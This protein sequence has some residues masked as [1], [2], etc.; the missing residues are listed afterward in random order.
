VADQWVELDLLG[1]ELLVAQHLAADE[2]RHAVG[3]LD[4]CVGLAEHAVQRVEGQ[5]LDAAV[6]SALEPRV[7]AREEAIVVERD[8]GAD[9]PTTRYSPTSG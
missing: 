7:L 6:G 1:V 8:V 3:E 5:D 4:R 2:D 9:R